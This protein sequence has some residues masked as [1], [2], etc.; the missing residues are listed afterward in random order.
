VICQPEG[1]SAALPSIPGTVEEAKSIMEI[2]KS[3]RL[4]SLLLEGRETNSTA[5][6]DAMEKYTCVHLACHAEQNAFR[7]LQ[8]RFYVGVDENDRVGALELSTIMKLQLKRADI[9]FL[10]ACQTSMGSELMSEEAVHLAAGMLAA[11]YRGVVATMWGIQ[12]E[13][14]PLV[15]GRFYQNLLS[16][17]R[18]PESEGVKDSNQRS[19]KGTA[20]M[21]GAHAAAALRHSL[22]E[23]RKG[24][25]LD[26]TSFFAWVPYVHFG[27]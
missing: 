16:R 11:G 17:S 23:L 27:L 1:V 7:P 15:A 19:D 22:K 9:A 24:L 20:Y 13:V 26:E 18:N 14:A 6:L 3:N 25:G 10:S 4:D 2:A 12:D 5:V 21:D 8:S